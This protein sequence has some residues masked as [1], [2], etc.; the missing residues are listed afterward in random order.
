MGTAQLFHGDDFCAQWRQ[1]G[2]VLDVCLWGTADASTEPTAIAAM[3]EA[4]TVA[5]SQHLQQVRVDLRAIEFMA[6]SC[7]RYFTSWFTGLQDG[8]TRK[9]SVTLVWDPG[10]SWQERFKDTV[11]ALAPAFVTAIAGQGP[12]T[13][14]PAA[15][16]R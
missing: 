9:Y 5:E 2:T 10:S 6:S 13:T 4:R 12:N 1:R 7:L 15:P 11:C 8:G 16:R 3:E 14:R